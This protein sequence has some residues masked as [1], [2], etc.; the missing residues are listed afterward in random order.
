MGTSAHSW[1]LAFD[2]ERQA[3]TQLQQL[4]GDRTVQLIDT[5]DPLEAA[6]LVAELGGP[7][8][9]VRLDSGDFVQ[10]SKQVRKILDDAGLTSAKIMASGDLEEHKIEELLAAGAPIDAFGV[11]T[12][13]ATS[14]DAPNMGAIYKLVEIESQGVTRYTAKHSPQ[15]STLPGAKQLFRYSDFDLLGLHDEC[16]GGSE[17]ML[18][19]LIIGGTLVR[20]MPDVASIRRRA[21]ENLDPWPSEPKR[22]GRSH[23]LE[24]LEKKY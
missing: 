11:G 2:S 8:W 23:A 1:V 21:Q 15:K 18:K 6:K 14:A 22:M 24:E 3:F 16:A 12:E 17:A 7:L 9:G 5:Y 20:E 4:L 13:L 19:P 10:Q